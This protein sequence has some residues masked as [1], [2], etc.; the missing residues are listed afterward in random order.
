MEPLGDRAVKKSEIGRYVG[1]SLKS[2]AYLLFSVKA[3]RSALRC[4]EVSMM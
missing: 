3:S 2:Y 1:E 4:A